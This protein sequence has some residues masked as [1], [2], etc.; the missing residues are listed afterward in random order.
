MIK[1]CVYYDVDRYLDDMID[2]EYLVSTDVDLGKL[3]ASLSEKGRLI[4]WETVDCNADKL[5]NS[6]APHFVYSVDVEF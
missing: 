2:E 3:I 1:V 6:F 5:S 4:S